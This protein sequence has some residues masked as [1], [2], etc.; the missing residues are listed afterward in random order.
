MADYDGF[1]YILFKLSKMRIFETK[2]YLVVY[3]NKKGVLWP[4]GLVWVVMC[5]LATLGM[6]LLLLTFNRDIAM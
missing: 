1:V 5:V 6:L 4:S 3:K 2:N